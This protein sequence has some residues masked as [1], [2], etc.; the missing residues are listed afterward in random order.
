MAS[1]ALAVWIYRTM[2]LRATFSCERP[3][4]VCVHRIERESEPATTQTIPLSDVLGAYYQH[5]Y[6]A[7]SPKAREVLA[8]ARTL[9]DVKT[10]DVYVPAP[11]TGRRSGQRV[12]VFTHKG[13]V[14]VTP[15]FTSNGQI[16]VHGFNSFVKGDGQERFAIVEDLYFE[17]G[18][19]TILPSLFGIVLIVM[20]GR[21]RA[22]D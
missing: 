17:A 7:E 2:A 19:S 22:F 5:A 6:W 4:G 15:E 14:P 10:E 9:D 1:L 18:V 16:D 8:R 20:P 11:G 12:I 13:F 21:S 3:T